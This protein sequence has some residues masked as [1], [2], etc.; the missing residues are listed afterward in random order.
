MNTH[1][2]VSRR[3]GVPAELCSCSLENFCFYVARFGL[4]KSHFG[5]YDHSFLQTELEPYPPCRY[6]FSLWFF[7]A[8]LI[9]SPPVLGTIHRFV[10]SFFFAADS[11]SCAGKSCILLIRPWIGSFWYFFINVGR[12]IINRL[13]FPRGNSVDPIW[14]WDVVFKDGVLSFDWSLG[15][16]FHCLVIL[17]SC[18]NSVI[19][20][21]IM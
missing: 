18:F 1:V 19:W 16:L 21:V 11:C 17:S 8:C 10:G 6:L 7:F 2:C 15:L 3:Y 14:I 20:F 12:T 5:W 4:V 13:R 9:L